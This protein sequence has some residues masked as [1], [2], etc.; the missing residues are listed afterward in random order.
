MYLLKMH[1]FFL[2]EILRIE[3]NVLQI[4]IFK[5]WRIF[6]I[7]SNKIFIYIFT[8]I[9]IQN[10]SIFMLQIEKGLFLGF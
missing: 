5:Y 4:S 8:F 1:T 9:K 3:S 10:I 2:N 7:I 6:Q